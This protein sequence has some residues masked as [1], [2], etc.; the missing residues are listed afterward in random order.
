M[1]SPLWI[2]VLNLERCHHRLNILSQWQPSSIVTGMSFHRRQS[3][4]CLAWKWICLYRCLHLHGASYNMLKPKPIDLHLK[5][6]TFDGTYII[7]LCLVFGNI[8][9]RLIKSAT[10]TS[11]FISLHGYTFVNC[12]FASSLVLLYLWIKVQNIVKCIRIRNPM[13]AR[14]RL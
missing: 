11:S 6:T 8:F 12:L 13:E 14:I 7:S 4:D 5:V 2:F 3:I 1:N 10:E 9:L